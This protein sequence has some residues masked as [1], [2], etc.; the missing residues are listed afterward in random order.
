MSNVLDTYMNVQVF[1]FIGLLAAFILAIVETFAIKPVNNISKRLIAFAEGNFRS[2]FHGT[3]LAS[4]EL[5]RLNDAV[6][7][8]G[9]ALELKERQEQ[10]L[11][12]TLAQL[13]QAQKME[14]VGNL[15]GGI[16]HDFNNLLGILIGN[17]DLLKEML[18][19]DEE[20][21]ELVDAALEAAGAEAGDDV[22]IGEIVF[23]Y[24]PSE[25]G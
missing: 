14:T 20:A 18:E 13:Q 23:T 6:N 22:R 10:E 21:S 9:E 16:A 5:H 12:E 17:L 25:E 2:D 11:K 8:L 15:T 3:R 7:K 24:V 1:V 4:S 19:S